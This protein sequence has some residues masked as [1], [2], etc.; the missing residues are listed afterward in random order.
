MENNQHSR[1]VSECLE[2]CL[3]ITQPNGEVDGGFVYD[4]VVY[5]IRPTAWCKRSKSTPE[6]M[7]WLRL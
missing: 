3:H 7:D 6:N 5:G 2:Y 1:A 4:R